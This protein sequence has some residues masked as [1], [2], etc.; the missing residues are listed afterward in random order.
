MRLYQIE[1]P[2]GIESIRLLEADPPSPG[3]GQV[4][5]RVHAV[6]LNY[7]DLAVASGGYPRAV[8][9]PLIPFSDGA[10]EVVEVG[11]G[12]DR[13][14]IGDRVAGIFM[15]SWLTGPMM[16]AYADSALGGALDGMLAEFVVLDQEGL[17]R[18][19]EHLSF[20]EAA[21]LPCAGVTAWHA[22]TDR[23]LAPGQT[24]LLLGTGGVAILTLQFAHLAGLRVIV[25]SSSEEKLARARELGASAGVNYLSNPEWDRS[26]LELTGGAGVDQV[27]ELGGSGT[28][29]RSLNAVALG[30]RVSL[31]GVLT[32]FEHRINPMGILGKQ[33][34]VH[35]VFVGSRAMFEAM[36]AAIRLHELRPVVDRVFGFDEVHDALRF[37]QAQQ[38]FGKIV[39]RLV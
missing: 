14:R 37:M 5:V 12:V 21:T 23:A 3:P 15:Q 34:E 22:L 10:G 25:T 18:I 28:L 4:Q 33:I 6:S 2:T 38:H 26:V 24:V 11:P 30:G 17:V 9:R 13:V 19:P 32:G 20:E 7:R 29:E 39:V 31:I 27:I 8:R 36:N 1:E 16:P 35:G